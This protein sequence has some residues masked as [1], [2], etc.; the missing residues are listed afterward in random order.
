MQMRQ[1]TIGIKARWGIELE[2]RLTVDK[3]RLADAFDTK[4]V[5]FQLQFK[6]TTVGLHVAFTYGVRRPADLQ[7]TLGATFCTNRISLV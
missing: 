6:G 2:F 5:R 4:S 3:G 7:R 1:G